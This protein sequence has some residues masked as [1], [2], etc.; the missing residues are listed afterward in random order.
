M[1][2]PTTYEDYLLKQFAKE[3]PS[4]LFLEV[5]VSVSSEP[6][7]ARRIDGVLVPAKEAT[8]YLENSTAPYSVKRPTPTWEI[9][10]D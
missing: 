2:Q 9:C 10:S 6:N 4:S 1:W 8:I 3:N 7:T 5:S